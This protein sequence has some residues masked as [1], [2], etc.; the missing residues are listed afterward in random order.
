VVVQQALV[1]EQEAQAQVVVEQEAIF[2][3]I[4]FLHHLEVTQ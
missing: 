3:L 1:R 4:H 2:L